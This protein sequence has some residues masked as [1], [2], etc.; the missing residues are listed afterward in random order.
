M[1]DKE[2]FEEFRRRA[3]AVREIAQYIFD[4]EDRET[5]L[6]FADDCEKLL[7]RNGFDFTLP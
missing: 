2:K 3:A 1:P 5:I 4:Q 7:M 6:E